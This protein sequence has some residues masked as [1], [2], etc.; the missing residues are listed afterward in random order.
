MNIPGKRYINGTHGSCSIDGIHFADINEMKLE[1]DID[2]VDVNQAGDLGTD[3]KMVGTKGSGS[4]KFNKVYSRELALILPILKSGKDIRVLVT[5]KID[6]PDAYGSEFIQVTDVWFNNLTLA[7]WK[8]K[9]LSNRELKIGFNPSNVEA[10]D[11]I[12]K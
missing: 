5:S 1:V 6:D 2:R 8:V 7:D 11:M 3:S 12:K 9:E 10:L 4:L